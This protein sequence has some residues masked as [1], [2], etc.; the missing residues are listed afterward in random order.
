MMPMP[1]VT[2]AQAV[3]APMAI[4]LRGPL[5]QRP[6]LRVRLRVGCP[7]ERRVVLCVQLQRRPGDALP[8]VAELDLGPD[9]P[10]THIATRSRPHALMAAGQVCIQARGIQ[11]DR[12]GRGSARSDCL[13]LT[14][15]LS[16]EPEPPPAPTSAG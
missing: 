12:T 2:S 11:L 6:E 4:T 9:L 15:V 7:A 3:A 8:V 16:I 14:G 13:R 1:T 10:S 5:A